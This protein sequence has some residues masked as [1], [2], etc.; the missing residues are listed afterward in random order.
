M[1]IHNLQIVDNVYKNL[2]PTLH[3]F[4]HWSPN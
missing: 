2:N 3:L 4:G 1:N